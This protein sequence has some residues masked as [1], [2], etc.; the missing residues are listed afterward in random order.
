MFQRR[1]S[2]NVL[3]ALAGLVYCYHPLG[4][5]FLS[6]YISNLPPCPLGSISYTQISPFHRVVQL[7][8]TN[9]QRKVGCRQMAKFDKAISTKFSHILMFKKS[10]PELQ[11]FGQVLAPFS[12]S[13]FALS[14]L[15]I[16]STL[17]IECFDASHF[18]KRNHLDCSRESI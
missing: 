16:H 17:D 13:S 10:T 4:W 11:S 5:I 2:G 1:N 8:C 6:Y 12:F 14:S 9:L 15:A 7:F 18:T 3:P